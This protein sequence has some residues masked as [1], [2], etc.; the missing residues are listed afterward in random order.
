MTTDAKQSQ[1]IANQLRKM[2]TIKSYGYSSVECIC[3]GRKIRPACRFEPLA[4]EERV[5]PDEP[6][7]TFKI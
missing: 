2:V 6:W 5:N 3:A 4:P 7:I 1:S